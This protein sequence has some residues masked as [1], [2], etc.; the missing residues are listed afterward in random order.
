MERQYGTRRCRRAREQKN[1][2]LGVALIGPQNKRGLIG[3]TCCRNSHRG[4]ASRRSNDARAENFRWLEIA[5]IRRKLPPPRA[6]ETRRRV[7]DLRIVKLWYEHL[8]SDPES[9]VKMGTDSPQRAGAGYQ[10]P[11]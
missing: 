11:S 5:R 9:S 6:I 4:N 1:S 8:E 3:V 7:R 2:E 10:S